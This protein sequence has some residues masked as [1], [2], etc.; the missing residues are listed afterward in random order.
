M[1]PPT[2]NILFWLPRGLAILFT[3]IISMFAADVFS[4]GGGFWKTALAFALHLVPTLILAV[5]IIVSWRR[6]WIGALVFFGLAAGYALWSVARPDWILVI[7]GP[8][9]LIAVLYLL[10][11]RYRDEVRPTS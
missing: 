4:E 8:L 10:G 7:A 11:W 1:K 6:E 5:A 9:A 2:K 3:L